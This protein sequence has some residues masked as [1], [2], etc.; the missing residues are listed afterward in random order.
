MGVVFLLVSVPGVPAIPRNWHTSHRYE[1][2][3]VLL[4]PLAGLYLL[5]QSVLATLRE[6]KFRQ[7]RLKL[8]TLPGVIGGRV[9]GNLKTAFLFPPGTQMKLTLTCVRSYVS[10]SGDSRSH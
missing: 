2:L 4:F 9:E 10:G 3:L 8:S 6:A 1:T 5:S 7:M